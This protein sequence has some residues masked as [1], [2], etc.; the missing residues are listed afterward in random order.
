[1]IGSNLKGKNIDATEHIFHVH[2]QF[3]SVPYIVA[4]L[5]FLNGVL[6]SSRV[7]TSDEVGDTAS[8]TGA[9]VP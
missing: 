4:V 9:G 1:M 5:V 2:K 6:N 7:T 3:L 8:N